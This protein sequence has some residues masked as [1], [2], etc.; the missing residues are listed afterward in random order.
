[1]KK[2][3]LF[4]TLLIYVT[5][6]LSETITGEATYQW[7]DLENNVQAKKSAKA[8]AIRTAVENFATSISSETIVKDM[9]LE[10]DVVNLKSRALVRNIIDLDQKV[11]KV[12]NTIYH[13]ISC[14][15]DAKEVI[16][17]L[18][19]WAA[20]GDIKTSG[21]Y[22]YGEGKHSRKRKADKKAIENIITNIA[23]D[24]QNKYAGIKPLEDDLYDFTESIISTYKSSFD[25]CQ[26]KVDG[27][28]TL[29]YIKKNNLIQLFESRVKKID[30][31][32]DMGMTA[33]KELRIGDAIKYYYWALSLLR[34]HPEHDKLKNENFGNKL[35][36]LALPDRINQIFG[37]ISVEI[38]KVSTEDNGNKVVYINFLYNNATINNIGYSYFVNGDWSMLTDA[39]K[40]LSICEFDKKEAGDLKKIKFRIEYRYESASRIDQ[41][42][43]DVIENVSNLYLPKSEMYVYIDKKY[44]QPKKISNPT[45]E[46]KSYKSKGISLSDIDI[47][48]SKN[49][50]YKEIKPA[51]K[52]K[53]SS[54]VAKILQAINSKDYPSV[55]EYF[56]KDGY[57]E[58][59]NIISYGNAKLLSTDVV[60]KS[61]QINDEIVVRS[62]PMQFE[63]KSN[64]F[65][66]TEN[67]VFTFNK[68]IKVDHLSY[69]LSDIAINSIM[70]KPKEFATLQ[71]RLQLIQFM[72]Y[73]KTAYCLKEYDFIKQVFAENALIIVGKVLKHDKK[74]LGE[75]YAQL[76]NDKVKY[77]RMKK[78]E[79]MEH[80]QMVFNSKEYINLRFEDNMFKKIQGKKS[81]FGIQIKQKYYSSNYADEGYLF[82]MIDLE[83]SKKPK[84]YVRSW[85]PEQNSD[86]SV[87]GLDDFEF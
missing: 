53:C 35:L 34:S 76:G 44:E 20:G 69:S 13:K 78:S 3:V 72:E 6:M 10:S 24:L 70:D 83:N 81:L 1:M 65:K 68:D 22:Y 5:A 42:L 84:I 59:I 45:V 75:M 48:M 87:I 38:S 27:K 58:F 21:E 79:Y 32:V 9:M 46:I 40:G 52:Q 55:E 80:L 67:V 62:I 33:E 64:N 73:Y 23:D 15:I 37:K 26:K 77:I 16:E 17:E 14:E 25:N 57:Q 47:S 66:T 49:Q 71:E 11:D 39:R 54:I 51:V 56:T 50:T 63:F 41:E 86:G 4:L 8:L 28:T 12:N 82:L 7:G 2:A 74:K 30:G 60:L 36:S 18:K 61:G 43:K 19:K 29:R 85:Q 31:Y